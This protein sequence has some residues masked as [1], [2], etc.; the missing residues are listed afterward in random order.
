MK[1]IVDKILFDANGI[2]RKKIRFKI[3]TFNVC[4]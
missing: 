1:E 3:L 2:N 4:K